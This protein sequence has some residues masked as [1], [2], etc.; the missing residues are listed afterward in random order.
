MLRKALISSSVALIS[1]LILVMGALAQGV[2]PADDDAPAIIV[3]PSVAAANVA[4]TVP[5]TLTLV[6]SGPTGPLTVEVPVFLNL[7]IRIGISPELT[8]TVDVTSSVVTT[9][10]VTGIEISP[11][12]TTEAATDDAEDSVAVV[13]PAATGA[14]PTVVPTPTPVPPAPTPTPEADAPEADAPEPTAP[15]L[16]TP[17]PEPTVAEPVIEA[18]ICSD[19]RAVIVAPGMG[20]V[21]AGDVNILGTAT[22]EDFQYFKLEYAAGANVDPNAGFAYLAGANVPVTGGV[23]GTFDS[24]TLDNGEYTLKLTVVDSVGNFPPPCTV[25]VVIAN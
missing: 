2:T 7:D 3:Q 16:P 1:L 25:S 8:A 24:T 12:S 15:P 18:P 14:A 11:V 20:Q 5:V 22:H 4:Q 17:T 13:T 23:L 19:P 9:D 6:I 10:A 21:V